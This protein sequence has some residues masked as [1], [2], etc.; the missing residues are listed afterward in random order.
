[1]AVGFGVYFAKGYGDV[2][3]PTP[4]LSILVAQSALFLLYAFYLLWQ[5]KRLTTA[6]MLDIQQAPL[7]T[8]GDD[9]AAG[10]DEELYK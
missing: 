3:N 4:T 10:F 9:A 8:T 6:T 5:R 1:M 2:L 7:T